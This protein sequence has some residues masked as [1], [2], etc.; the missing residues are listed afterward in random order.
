MATEVAQAS[1]A[2]QLIIGR[3]NHLVLAGLCLKRPG[4]YG[5][6]ILR[7]ERRGRCIFEIMLM[8]LLKAFL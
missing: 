5:R 1:G 4:F 8:D 7:R 3:D 2:D 6:L